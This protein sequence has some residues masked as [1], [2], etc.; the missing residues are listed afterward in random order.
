[1][2]F[3]RVNLPRR[4]LTFET[5]IKWKLFGM[6]YLGLKINKYVRNWVEDHVVPQELLATVK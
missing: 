2:E 5:K 1:M 4:I 3:C 6:S